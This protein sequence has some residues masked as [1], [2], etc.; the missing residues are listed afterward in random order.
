MLIDGP[1]KCNIFII[2][3]WNIVKF[4]IEDDSQTISAR[5]IKHK[6]YNYILSKIIAMMTINTFSKKNSPLKNLCFISPSPS[7]KYIATRVPT[8]SPCHPLEF[9]RNDCRNLKSS[10]AQTAQTPSQE[11]AGGFGVEQREDTVPKTCI[12]LQFHTPK[13][14]LKGSNKKMP[15]QNVFSKSC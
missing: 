13:G 4:S 6:S 1:G 10:R 15:K 7:P 11:S 8:P 14:M 9:H 2:T 5:N 12:S 3:T